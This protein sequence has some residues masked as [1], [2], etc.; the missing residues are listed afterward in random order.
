MFWYLAIWQVNVLPTDIPINI[1]WCDYSEHV[2]AHSPS[3]RQVI[4]HA[5][6]FLKQNS[7]SMLLRIWLLR[8]VFT[9]LQYFNKITVLHSSLLWLYCINI[10]RAKKEGVEIQNKSPKN[11]EAKSCRPSHYK[12]NKIGLKIFFH[13]WQ[14]LIDNQGS[15]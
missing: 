9:S 14:I 6:T 1:C 4:A 13:Y 12:E 11:S 8:S 10:H 7:N 5:A 2:L 15:Y 3:Q